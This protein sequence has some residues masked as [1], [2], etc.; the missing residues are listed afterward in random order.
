MKKTLSNSELDS[1]VSYMTDSLGYDFNVILPYKDGVAMLAAL[2]KAEPIQQYY[3]GKL[4]FNDGRRDIT[5]NIVHQKEYREAK[6]IKLLGVQD[7][8]PTDPI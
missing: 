2:E 1:V 8:E 5:T 7:D 3:H 6:M 4:V